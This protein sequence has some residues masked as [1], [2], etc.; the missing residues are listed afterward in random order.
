MSDPRSTMDMRCPGAFHKL[1]G[2]IRIVDGN[3]IELA[4]NDCARK[5]R[6]QGETVTQ[7]LHRFNVLGELIETQIQ[8]P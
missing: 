2:R 4:C 8:R 7:V 1:L 5:M 6:A 3:L